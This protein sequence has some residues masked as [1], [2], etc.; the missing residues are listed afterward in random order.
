MV[1]GVT[2]ENM[3]TGSPSYKQFQKGD[4]ILEVPAA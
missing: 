2:V 4:V 3:L 1:T